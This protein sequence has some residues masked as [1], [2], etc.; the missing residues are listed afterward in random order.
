MQSSLPS[1]QCLGSNS[2][3][4]LHYEFGSHNKDAMSLGCVALVYPTLLA[5][6]EFYSN[7]YIVRYTSFP[8]GIYPRVMCLTS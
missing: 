1:S 3:L 4:V 2:R 8:H 6:I 7:I 5:F